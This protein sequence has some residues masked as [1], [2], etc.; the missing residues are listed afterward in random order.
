MVVGSNLGTRRPAIVIERVLFVSSTTVGGSGRSQRQLGRQLAGHGVEVLFLVDDGAG[1]CARWAYGHA[2]DL[3]GRLEGRLGG[4]LALRAERVFGRRRRPTSLEDLPHVGAAVPQNA[5]ASVLDEFKPDV[6]IVNSVE[7][8][9]WRR[10]HTICVQRRIPTVLYVR[11]DDSLRHLETGSSPDL[12][13][14]NARSLQVA[15]TKQGHRCEFVPSVIDPSATATEST[16]SVCLMVNP[17]ESR[18]LSIAC[19]LAERLPDIPFV[20]Q[21]SW[22]LDGPDLEAARRCAEKPNVEFRR[23]VPPGPG[24]YGDT[25]L[26]LVPYRVDNRPRVIPEA[27]ANGIPVVAAD[28]PA[29]VEAIGGGGVVVPLE[30]IDRWCA[31]IRD[32]WDDTARYESAVAAARANSLRKDFDPDLAA[33]TFLHLLHE[34]VTHRIR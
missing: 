15:L 10:I 19:L 8:L 20:L 14:A 27:H 30:D 12:L 23:V 17:I 4:T 9:Q 21:E 31:A 18:G 7:R 6:V 26:L 5:L 25:R 11:E 28:V 32:L 1:R 24:L 29:L 33:R 16:R 2:S 34:V 13:V 3:T 22:P